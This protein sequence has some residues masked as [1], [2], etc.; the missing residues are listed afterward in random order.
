MKT[1]TANISLTAD[2]LDWANKKIGAG[3]NNLSEVIRDALRKQRDAEA[4]D[5]LNPPPLPPGTMARIYARQSKAERDM[6]L[7]LARRAVR[8]PESQ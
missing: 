1:K 8:T 4:R 2:L 3:Y 6:E 7:R 5:Y